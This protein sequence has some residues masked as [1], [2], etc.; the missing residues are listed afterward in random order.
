MHIE[1]LIM[2]PTAPP[3]LLYGQRRVG[4][5]SLLRNLRRMLPSTWVTLFVDLQALASAEGHAGFLFQ[6]ARTLSAQL[7]GEQRTAIE[8]PLAG[9]AKVEPFIV[10]DV[11]LDRLLYRLQERSAPCCC[12]MNSSSSISPC[13]PG[14]STPPRARHVATHHPAQAAATHPRCRFTHV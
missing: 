7:S 4:K 2:S 1:K 10:F 14:R 6:L 5:T 11:W 8:F 13:A 3:L 12:W 9:G